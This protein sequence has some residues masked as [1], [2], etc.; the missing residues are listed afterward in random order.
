MKNL[1][2][3]SLMGLLFELL[4]FLCSIAGSGCAS[5]PNVQ[6]LIAHRISSSDR[7][8]IIMG[9]KGEFSAKASKAKIKRLQGQVEATR[10]LEQQVQLMQSI[11]RSPLVAGNKV[12]L[13]IDGKATYASMFEAIRN[14][15]DSINFETFIF[16]D[17]EVGKKFSDLLIQKRAEGV[18]VNLI[19]DSFGSKNTPV[20]FFQRLREASVLVVEFNPLN[21]W[22]VLA[23]KAWAVSHR[24][25]RKILVVDGAIAFTGGV[26]VSAV[27]SGSSSP[28]TSSVKKD[29]PWRDTHVRI[30][31]PAAARFQR[32]FI[33][34][35]ERQ[36]GPPL[37]ARNYF[38][39][40]ER[41]GNTLVRVVGSLPGES[42]RRIF[43]MYISAITHAE[44]SVYLTTPY[45]VPD[46]QMLK[47]LCDAAA[48][49]VDVKILLPGYSDE[50]LVFYASRY[51]Y[52]RL[53]K[54]GVQLYERRGGMLHAKTAVID[55]VWSTIGSS[56][57]DNQSFLTNDEANAV[58]LGRGFADS[59]ET[60]FEKDLEDSDQISLDEWEKRS[61]DDRLKEWSANLLKHWL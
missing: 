40:I 14:A 26:N 17:D 53:L 15:K 19:Y 43:M 31:G 45:F 33:N 49:G 12:T 30:E 37:P 5:L 11:S 28:R 7:P 3:R 22:K 10:L 58:I 29:I 1:S 54:A 35:W 13:L 46:S 51:Y 55:D 27:Y 9:S 60:M 39:H 56:N 16:D 20:S 36:K 32:L 25:H 50:A 48:R 2:N 44:N 18:Q 21:P 24:D 34:T 61:Q 42:N 38:P 6:K 47:A 8:A 52:T 59:M 41:A 57:L 23:G 4:A